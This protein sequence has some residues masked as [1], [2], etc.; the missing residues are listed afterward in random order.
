M[1][2]YKVSSDQCQLNGH[3]ADVK[4]EVIGTDL[5][6]IPAATGDI[7]V[8][9]SDYQRFFTNDETGEFFRFAFLPLFEEVTYYSKASLYRSIQEKAASIKRVQKG[10][11]SALDSLIIRM[12]KFSNIAYSDIA[13]HINFLKDKLLAGGR[14]VPVNYINLSKHGLS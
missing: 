5:S 9:T 4:L 12:E 3:Y 11:K 8:A 10:K 6:D 7:W 1:A 14:I 2:E 13:G